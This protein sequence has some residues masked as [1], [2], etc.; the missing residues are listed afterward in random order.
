MSIMGWNCLDVSLELMIKDPKEDKVNQIKNKLEVWHESKEMNHNH[1]KESYLY[2][3]MFSRFIHS[4][5]L[6]AM[7]ICAP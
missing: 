7:Y 3:P 6:Q 2:Q 4:L 5:W 1:Y